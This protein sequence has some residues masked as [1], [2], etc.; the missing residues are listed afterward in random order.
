MF[1]SVE[2]T[3]VNGHI[4]LGWVSPTNDPNVVQTAPSNWAV[5]FFHNIRT[6]GGMS[7]QTIH[8]TGIFTYIYH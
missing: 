7:T 3:P 6:G 1:F 5:V 4:P 2:I 8:G